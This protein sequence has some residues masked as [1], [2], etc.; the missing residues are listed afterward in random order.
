MVGHFATCR[1]LK[2]T[3]QFLWAQLITNRISF[4]IVDVAI[5]GWTVKHREVDSK[6]QNGH[7]QLVKKQ[8][9]FAFFNAIIMRERFA[10]DGL[11]FCWLRMETFKHWRMQQRRK[12]FFVYRESSLPLV[13][14]SGRWNRWRSKIIASK[15]AWLRYQQRLAR[16]RSHRTDRLLT[17]LK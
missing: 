1:Q 4:W 9:D 3:S 8:A 2:M 5:A 17:V 11:P 13:M 12:C 6:C 15:H 14:G 10:T 7:P 16:L